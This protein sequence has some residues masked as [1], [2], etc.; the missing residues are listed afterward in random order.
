V[1]AAADKIDSLTVAFSLGQ[2]PT[3]SRDPFGLR[4]AA[5][6]LCRLALEGNLEIE[7]GALVS[8]THALLVEQSAEVEEDPAD[9]VDF[10]EERLEGLLDVPVEFV[11]AARAG[12][13]Q[14]LGA[15]ARLAEALAAAA[16]GPDFE[17]AYVAFDRANRLAGKSDGAAAELDPKLATDEAELALIGALAGASPTISA[18]LEAREFDAALTAAAG[19]RA[20]VDRFFDEVLV[21]AEDAQ[22]RANRLRL[23]LDVRDAV[24]AL[25][26]LSQIPR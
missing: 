26:D 11:R 2:W 4:R 1:L 23:L 14:E 24:G 21:M 22:V 20:P 17:G 9:V 10:V 16:E 19:L 5:I 18:A 13:V 15:V 6:G 8:R 12:G 7:L 25:G 3:G